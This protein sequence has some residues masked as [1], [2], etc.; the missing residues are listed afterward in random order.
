MAIA[1]ETRRLPVV[2]CFMLL[3]ALLSACSGGSTSSTSAPQGLPVDPQKW[4]CPDSLAGA[5]P[6]EIA[7]WCAS[8]PDRG[9]P[10]PEAL[11]NPPPLSQL[12]D[13]NR[14][15]IA[16]EAFVKAESY[17]RELGWLGD[18]TWRFTGP[19]VGE[20]GS[21]SNYGTHLPVRIYYSP[22]VIDWLCNDRQGELPEGATI[23]KEMHLINDALDVTLDSQG[24]MVI[25]ADVGPQA[26]AMMIKNNQYAH[27][28]WFWPLMQRDQFPLYAEE[29]VDPPIV[30]RSAFPAESFVS[31]L[32]APSAPDPDWYPTG[33][34]FENAAKIPNV[35]SP[36][37][38][39]GAFCFS[40]HSSAVSEQTFASLNNL[41]GKSIRYKLF[42]AT[43]PADPGA[44]LDTHVLA[45]RLKSEPTPVALP[46][47]A[48]TGRAAADD[49]DTPFT[50]PLPT[51]GSRFLSF[52]DQLGEVSFTDA[53]QQR[54]PAQTYDHVISTPNGPSSF[55]TSD[56][57][58]PCHDALEYLAETSNMTVKD[59]KDGSLQTINLSPY[60]EWNVSPMGVAG[61]DPIFF[62]QLEGE[63]NLLPQMTACIEDTCLHCHGVMGQRQFATDTESQGDDACKAL[64]GVAPP[65]EVPFGRPFRLD[66]VKQ[67]P[68]SVP[69][70]EQ[71]YGAL[72]RDGISCN[73]CHRIAAQDLGTENTFT[74]NFI[75]AP[76]D[77]E[78]GPYDEVTRK[79]MKN[80]LGITPRFGAQIANADLCGSCHNV[81]LPIFTNDG[82]QSGFSYEQATQLEW[83]NSDY[84]PNRPLS[85]S[86]Q[87]CHMP[88]RYNGEALR[89]KIANFESAGFAPTTNRVPDADITSPQ[90]TPYGR[91][92][93]HG[94]N[95]FLNEIFQQFPLL[96]GFR[97]AERFSRTSL[98]YPPLL[99]GEDSIVDM[100]QN[101]T[102]TVEI[103]SLETTAEGTL[104]AVVQVTNRTGHKLPSGVGFRRL[105]IEFLARD[106]AGNVLWASGRTNGLGALVVGRTDVVLPTEQ[107]D[108]FPAAGFQ[109]HYQTITQEDQVQIYQEVIE[110]SQG[111]VTTSFLHR[112]DVVKDNRIR[113]QGYDPRFYDSFS[114]P[115][116]QAL[117]VTP[118][119]AKDDPDYIDPARTGADQIEYLIPLDAATLARVNTVSVT[120]YSQSIPP[121]YLAERFNNAGRGTARKNEIERFYY[122]ASHLNTDAAT[123]D[124]GRQVLTDWKLFLTTATKT[125]N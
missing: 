38:G 29:R 55:L 21:G 82:R 103:T 121:P 104:R 23:I 105:F 7:A 125:L 26:W 106:A 35:I 90:R 71:Q 83:L 75:A 27:D 45:L 110:D 61:R 73:V 124:S 85:Q 53:W 79:P 1:N 86:C 6:A 116:I 15:E 118:G 68:D 107:P 44:G 97:Q 3:S 43:S 123:D 36:Q 4:V 42:A 39:Y 101:Q 8:H 31:Q 74:G 65:P 67:W 24:C 11:R 113:P 58:A 81:L 57:C 109:P 17:K 88:T 46:A 95:I 62:S 102:L 40:C 63:T 30:D 59:E 87:G 10:L 32:I 37:S 12:A 25:N 5:T 84:A 19:Y 22:E 50:L 94:L 122:M 54:L 13:K 93:L 70:A 69:N 99:L 91:H 108:R 89:F 66:M 28:R 120:L 41:L 48:T 119:T 117:A 80:A 18:A 14:Y 115:Y 9:Q 98:D 111:Q 60:G 2:F 92:S 33:Y 34:F 64:F 76:L 96:L 49:F 114:S 16:L 52:Y 77:E 47:H 51:A 56:Q 72:A 78:Y 100:A 20:I 112:F